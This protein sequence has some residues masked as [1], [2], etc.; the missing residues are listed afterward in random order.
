MLGPFI[1]TLK[2][3]MG[4][5]LKNTAMSWDETLLNPTFDAIP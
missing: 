5:H 1:E 4:E 3:L 2:E